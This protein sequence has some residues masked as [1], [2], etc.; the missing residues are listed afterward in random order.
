MDPKLTEESEKFILLKTNY[1]LTCEYCHVVK[2]L[3]R[4]S[5]LS[6]VAILIN[7][8][9]I[10]NA[11]KIIKI[12]NFPHYLSD[13]CFALCVSLSLY[14]SIC[15]CACFSLSLPPYSFLLFFCESLFLIK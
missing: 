5:I 1:Y 14:L 6:N 15:V 10:I 12:L 13:L 7:V 9:K 3:K 4:L 2:M 8:F 11:V